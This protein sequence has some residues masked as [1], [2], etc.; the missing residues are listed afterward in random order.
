MYTC[1]AFRWKRIATENVMFTEL[2]I[3]IWYSLFSQMRAQS[4]FACFRR[5]QEDYR[6]DDL[7]KLEAITRHERMKS[8]EVMG[9]LRKDID[10]LCLANHKQP[11]RASAAV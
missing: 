1:E 9:T 6:E 2:L 11:G 4:I 5:T 8:N 10:Q 3:Y 7:N